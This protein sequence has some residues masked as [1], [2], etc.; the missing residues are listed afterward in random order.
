M[1]K[2]HNITSF[3]REQFIYTN[4]PRLLLFLLWKSYQNPL[5][6]VEV[7]R[8]TSRQ[9]TDSYYFKAQCMYLID[10][11]WENNVCLPVV[12][13]PQGIYLHSCLGRFLVALK[14]IFV[15]HA[16]V[17]ENREA[18][19]MWLDFLLVPAQR[20]ARTGTLLKGLLQ[21]ILDF[22]VWL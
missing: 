22:S 7:S 2:W 12:L 11:L 6:G 5:R 3:A 10:M 21:F 20:A 19:D 1:V 9:T 16:R 8:E 14:E 13:A 4:R 17:R 15:F 18:K